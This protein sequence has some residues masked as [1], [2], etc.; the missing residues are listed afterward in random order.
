LSNYTIALAIFKIA[1]SLG[2]ALSNKYQLTRYLTYRAMIDRRL[3][4][5]VD[6]DVE[7]TYAIPLGLVYEQP[8]FRNGQLIDRHELAI[9]AFSYFESKA[10]LNGSRITTVNRD[11][12]IIAAEMRI[13]LASAMN[14]ISVPPPFPFSRYPGEGELPSLVEGIPEFFKVWDLTKF[15]K[16]GI[17]TNYGHL[18]LNVFKVSSDDTIIGIPWKPDRVYSLQS[19]C[20]QSLSTYNRLFAGD[21]IGPYTVNSCA[22][23]YPDKI[24]HLIDKYNKP[25]KELPIKDFRVSRWMFDGLNMMYDYMGMLSTLIN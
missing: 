12:N 22:N 14:Q 21:S 25:T 3:R 24:C 20:M 7:R 6:G 8:R 17:Y 15:N 10:T 1:A 4:F 2:R 19:L 18:A 11:E 13:E 23:M 9:K 5:E 16:Y